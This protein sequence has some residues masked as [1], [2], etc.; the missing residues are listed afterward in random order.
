[1][2]GRAKVTYPELSGT[3]LFFSGGG[4]KPGDRGAADEG[5]NVAVSYPN[6][7]ALSF[8]DFLRISTIFILWCITRA[9][10]PR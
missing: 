4:G 7:L 5:V 6:S 1:L 3:R 8:V 10:A 9:S 2:V